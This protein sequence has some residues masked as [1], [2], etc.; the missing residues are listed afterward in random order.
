[1][2]EDASEACLPLLHRM[3]LAA[4]DAHRDGDPMLLIEV[5][6]AELRISWGPT[7]D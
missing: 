1:V 4:V 2:I 5:G 7:G 6:S 3:V